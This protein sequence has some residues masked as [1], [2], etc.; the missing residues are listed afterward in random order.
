MKNYLNNKRMMVTEKIAKNLGIEVGKVTRTKFKNG[1]IYI[2]FDESVR[3]ADVFV[4]QTCCK[5]VNASIVE[6]LILNC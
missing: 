5:P 3:G 2:R 4:V 6:L 1:E